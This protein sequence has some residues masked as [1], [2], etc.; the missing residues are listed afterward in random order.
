M[1]P[2]A[3]RHGA[4]RFHLVAAL[5]VAALATALTLHFERATLRAP[6]RGY[7][8]L[9]LALGLGAAALLL[10]ALLYSSRRR[11]LQEVLPGRLR[12][13]LRV[14]AWISLLAV[15]LALLH[16]GF[17]L[18][19]PVGAWTFGLLALVVA[20]GFVGWGL[21]ALLPSRVA[22]PGVGNLA[23]DSTRRTIQR[24]EQRI[25]EAPAGRSETFR[26][27]LAH[28]LGRAARPTGVLPR[29]EKEALGEALGLIGRLRAERVRLVRQRR[30]HLGLRAWTWVHVPAAILLPFLLGYHVYDALELEW[31]WRRPTPA[32]FASPESCATC[33][34]RQYEEWIGSMHAMAMSSPTVDAQNRL[35]VARE[36]D[37][38]ATG[39]LRKALVGDLC[40]RCHAPTGHQ[41]FLDER[42]GVLATLGARAPASRFGVSCVTC[43]Q[44]SAL[45]ASD[46]GRDA[47]ERPFRNA[48]NFAWRPG[49]T[50][51]GLVGAEDENPFVGNGAHRGARN[52]ALG[53]PEFCASCHTVSVD[54]PG[55]EGAREARD[56]VLLLQDTY[57]EWLEGGGT[58]TPLNWSAL[59]VTCLDCH[60]RDLS[61][62][63]RRARAMEKARLPLEERLGPL[64]DALA[65]RAGRPLEGPSA[66]AAAPADGFDRP[67]VPR[68]RYLH[69]FV[70]VD[71]P[72]GRDR[73]YPRGHPRHGENARIR[74]QMEAR[75]ADL[76]RVAAGIEIARVEDGAVVVRVGNLLTG[77]HLP[78]GFAFARQMW[79]E[80]SL[81]ERAGA[82][83][84]AGGRGGRALR[85]D[86]PLDKDA[87]GLRNFQAVLWNGQRGGET[88]LQ[89]E[90]RDVLKGEAARRN[91]F[92]DRVNFLLPGQ[93][94]EIRVPCA[95]RRGE[96]VRVRLRFRALPVRFVRA[97]AARLRAADPALVLPSA[98]RATL[99]RRARHLEALAEDLRIFDMARDER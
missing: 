30:L 12:T 22:R 46:P 7:T 75:T 90:A 96:R 14:H 99:E 19:D 52:P 44:V 68:R 50:Q 16:G 25:E 54:R 41:P 95:V 80:V 98:D 42:E 32:D 8:P 6:A 59:G 58:K 13:W 48:G 73:P 9:G 74:T 37:L 79:I 76:L 3:P 56:R 18:D 57:Q 5:V 1:R 82:P 61:D 34:R 93:I 78:A 60:G 87:P 45:H 36:H 84:L 63:A 11:A 47:A 23:L 88:V 91:G 94:R 24:L 17:H 20:T 92:P 97:L 85:D 4:W 33:H 69:T 35:V 83:V 49:R 66:L 28:A 65:R 38:L 64:R 71:L 27:H 62:L 40:V 70:G 2:P 89:N 81:P 43:H 31:T 51:F 10:L 26:R 67:L 21:Y 15:W 72:L 77:H 86:E 55:G 29:G 53:G 39:A